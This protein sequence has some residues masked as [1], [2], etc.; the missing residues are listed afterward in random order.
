M[1]V[2]GSKQGQ[3]AVSIASLQANPQG[4]MV[5]NQ[6]IFRQYD[7]EGGEIG[8]EPSRGVGLF[9]TYAKLD[10]KAIEKMQK[11]K[12]IEDNLHENILWATIGQQN[13]FA[14][15]QHDIRLLDL[16]RQAV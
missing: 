16:L 11:K 5:V 12:I 14:V 9:K 4:D 7:Q 2:L 10:L 8:F 15:L 13:I 3:D 1:P 6:A